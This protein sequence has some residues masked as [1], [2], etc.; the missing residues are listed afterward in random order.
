MTT[1]A[2]YLST[3]NT[4]TNYSMQLVSVGDFCMFKLSLAVCS[5][6]LPESVNYKDMLY[7]RSNSRKTAEIVKLFCN[8]CNHRFAIFASVKLYRTEPECNCTFPILFCQ[9]AKRMIR[10]QVVTTGAHKLLLCHYRG[11]SLMDMSQFALLMFFKN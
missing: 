8:L 10:T 1:H 7:R 3:N 5:I 11:P 2:D 4:A 6:K 9:L